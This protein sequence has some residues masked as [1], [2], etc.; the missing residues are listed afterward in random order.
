[1]K[2]APTRDIIFLFIGTRLALMMVTYLSYILLTA[3]KYS[4]TPVDVA[5]LLTSWNHWDAANYVRIAQYGYQNVYDTAFFPLLPLLIFALAHLLGA[6][7]GSYLLAG[8]LISNG[9]LLGALFVVYHLASDARGDQVARRTL[10]YLCIFPTAFFFFSAYNESLF[11]LLV[12][13]AFLAMRRQRWWLAGL[14]GLLA[15]LTRSA[16]I[17]LVVPYVW[18]VWVTRES[19]A[20]TRWRASHLLRFLPAILIPLGTVIYSGYCW[21]LYNAPLSFAIVQ[22][23]WAR[24]TSWPWAGIWQSLYEIF[25]YQPFGSFNEVHIILDLS[26]TLGFLLLTILG[27]RKLRMSYNLWIALLLLYVLLN[28]ATTQH[29]A[30]V[31]NQRLVLEMFPGFITLAAL[32]ITHPRLHQAL[33]VVFPILLAILS[34]LFVMNRW[35]V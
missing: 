2:R 1:M 26:A 6:W 24:H 11:I 7:N 20:A 17:L 27:W 12:T 14:L 23:H 30:L 31:S 8:M 35:M 34:M 16:G 25:W 29:D 28:P 32:G 3:P 15:A 5:G 19:I 9:A 10:L 13:G 22:G 21:Y 4:N 18:E 33:M